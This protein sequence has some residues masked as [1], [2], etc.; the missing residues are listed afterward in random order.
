MKNYLALYKGIPDTFTHQVAHW[1]TCLVLSIRDRKWCKYSHTELCINGIGYSS[2]VRDGGVRA[3][4]I[5]FN[6][7]NWDLIELKDFNTEYA[8]AVFDS[9]KGHSYDWLGALGWGLPFLKQSKN[10]EYCFEI[11]AEM[12]GLPNAETWTP[13]RFV[14]LLKKE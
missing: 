6:S 11:T 3:K 2:S 1:V 12:L 13:E 10:K 5:D 14:K 4:Q 7:G 9:K 8:L